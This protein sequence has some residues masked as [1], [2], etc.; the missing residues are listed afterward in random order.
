MA[1]DIN[2][3]DIRYKVFESLLEYLYTDAVT[4]PGNLCIHVVDMMLNK[5]CTD[6]V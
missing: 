3:P 4:A 2:L 6:V 5:F 1:Q